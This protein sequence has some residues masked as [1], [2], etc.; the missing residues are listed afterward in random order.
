MLEQLCEGF[1]GFHGGIIKIPAGAGHHQPRINRPQ[2]RRHGLI[3]L[4]LQLPLLLAFLLGQV[5]QPGIQLFDILG[6]PGQTNLGLGR[7]FQ[8]IEVALFALLLFP[9]GFANLL[10][11]HIAIL[12]Q[13]QLTVGPVLLRA[14]QILLGSPDLTLEATGVLIQ[15]PDVLHDMLQGFILLVVSPDCS[16]SL[17]SDVS[18][19]LGKSAPERGK[20]LLAA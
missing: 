6:Q 13:Q 10:H 3:Q 8:G 1:N 7:T 4:V 17:L 5:G 20:I 11:G 14:L 12:G 19:G 18:Q 9:K 15:F 16:G 2:G